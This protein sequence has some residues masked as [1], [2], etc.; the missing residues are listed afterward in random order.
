MGYWK[1][2]PTILTAPVAHEPFSLPVFLDYCNFS[3]PSASFLS[4]RPSTLVFHDVLG[5]LTLFF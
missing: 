1:F 3:S 2:P 5:F 4:M